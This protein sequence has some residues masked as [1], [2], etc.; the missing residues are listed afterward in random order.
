MMDICH[1]GTSMDEVIG[2]PC[3]NCGHTNLVH[4]GPQNPSLTACAICEMLA[5]K[6][7]A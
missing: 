2:A 3:D 4:P 7:E 1:W 5:A 6:A